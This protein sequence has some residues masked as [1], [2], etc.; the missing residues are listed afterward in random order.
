MRTVLIIVINGL[1]RYFEIQRTRRRDTI[2]S[3]P[4][5]AVGQCFGR[6]NYETRTYRF[7]CSETMSDHV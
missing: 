7:N 3:F 1:S 2:A 5:H 6:F 4:N